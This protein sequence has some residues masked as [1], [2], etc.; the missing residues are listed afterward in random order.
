M[1]EQYD[2]TIAENNRKFNKLFIYFLFNQKNR[3]LTNLPTLLVCLSIIHNTVKVMCLMFLLSPRSILH[4]VATTTAT[5]TTRF[6]LR[7]RFLIA[8]KLIKWLKLILIA[9]PN[10]PRDAEIECQS[11][12]TSS[13]RS[14]A[15]I[16]VPNHNL[17]D[18]N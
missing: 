16:R 7:A 12:N 14:N 11:K 17:K 15:L 3:E 9:I 8:H 10:V 2:I 13:Y 6:Q 5:T 18:I 1:Q 4:I